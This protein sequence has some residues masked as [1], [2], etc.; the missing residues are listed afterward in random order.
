MKKHALVAAVAATLVLAGCN[1]DSSAAEPK[2]G[3]KST[4]VTDKST[5]IEQVSYVFGYDAGKSLKRIEEQLDIDVYMKAFKDGYAGA[6]SA[7][8]EEQIQTLGQAYEKRKTEE[9]MKK[10]EEAAATNKA[11]GDKFLAENAKKAGVQTTASRL[12]YKVITEGTGKSPTATDGV[13]AAYEGKLTDGTVFDSSE[14]EAVPF[15]LNQVIKGWTEGLQL[16]KEGGKYE[17]YVPSD[18][19]YGEN[20]AVNA[21]IGPNSVLIFTIDLKKVAD[22]K[23]IE[24]EQRAMME[25]QMR[26]LEQAQAQQ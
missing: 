20:G 17:L 23:T 8:T 15:M 11:E 18:L 22:Q 6:E 2:A 5:E 4:V 26:A 24:A 9:A 10:Q 7:L 14:G 3:E 1:K 13:Y 16:M 25:A 21:G 19:A 12:Q